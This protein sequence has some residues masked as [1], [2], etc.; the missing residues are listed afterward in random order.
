MDRR[1]PLLVGGARDL[2]LRLRTMRD[3]V[4]WSY[5]LLTPDEQ[6]LFRRL[7]VFEKGGYCPAKDGSQTA[8]ALYLGN[9]FICVLRRGGPPAEAPVPR[10][11]TLMGSGET[12]ERERES[13]PPRRVPRGCPRLL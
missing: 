13:P 7:A 10:C 9:T 12:F 4:A 3:A 5:D 8:S 11:E 1:L 2:P 6:R